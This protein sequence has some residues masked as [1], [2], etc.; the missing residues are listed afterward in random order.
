MRNLTTKLEMAVV[1]NC[2]KDYLEKKS[3]VLMNTDARD[4]TL[5]EEYKECEALKER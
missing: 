2:F 5:S 3:K 4:T 1:E